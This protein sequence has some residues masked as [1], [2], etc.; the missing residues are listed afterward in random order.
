MLQFEWPAT[1]CYMSVG[2]C[3]VA[4]AVEAYAIRRK[5]QQRKAL[6][7][8]AA[9]NGAT[10]YVTDVGADVSVHDGPDAATHAVPDTPG[11]AT[12]KKDK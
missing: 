9:S 4:L 6:A 12:S 5:R 11:K 2:Q 7:A 3:F 1:W 10:K 8:S